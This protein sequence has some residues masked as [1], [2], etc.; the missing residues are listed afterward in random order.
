VPQ[1]THRPRLGSAPRP[2]AE[3][4]RST[5]ETACSPS[6]ARG[7]WLTDIP[8]YVTHYHLADKTPFLNLSDLTEKEVPGVMRDLARRRKESGLQRVFGGRYMQLRRLTEVK[9]RQLFVDVGGMPERTT[10]HYFVLGTSAWYRGLAPDTH[11]VVVSLA[12]LPA[13][14]TSFTYPDSFTAM[15]YL[16][17][18]GLPYIECPYH[19]R[20][21]RIHELAEVISRHGLPADDP[22]GN[23]AG[24]QN[25]PFEKYIEVQ[26][27]TDEP[28]RHFWR[29]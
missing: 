18:F 21:F 16:P 23:Y 15:G 6:N 13:D 29:P 10:P 2:K 24:Y 27:W 9:L 22:S 4:R 7:G 11:E 25:K 12:D 19:G 3:P 5:G 8:D 20:A 14:Q 26:L 17:Q 1:L 28:I